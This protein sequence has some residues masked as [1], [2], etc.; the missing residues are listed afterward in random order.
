[1][2]QKKEPSLATVFDAK[3]QNTEQAQKLNPYLGM[4]G[5]PYNVEVAAPHQKKF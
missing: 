2:E 1:M 3:T 5:Y 4:M